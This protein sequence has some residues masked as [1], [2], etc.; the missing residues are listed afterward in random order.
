[1]KHFCQL[2]ILIP[3]LDFSE[4]ESMTMKYNVI[5][6]KKIGTEMEKNRGKGLR[7]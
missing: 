4:P 5:T 1:M 7:K 2:C 3:V 6:L